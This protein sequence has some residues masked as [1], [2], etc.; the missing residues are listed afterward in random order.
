MNLGH[1]THATSHLQKRVTIQQG[2]LPG[3][4]RPIPPTLFD[5][6]IEPAKRFRRKSDLSFHSFFILVHIRSPFSF[7]LLFRQTFSSEKN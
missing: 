3:P 1:T 6:T 5:R 4:F 2:H 7:S